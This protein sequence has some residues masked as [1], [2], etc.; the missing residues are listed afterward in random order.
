MTLTTCPSWRRNGRR[1]PDLDSTGEGV[2]GVSADEYGC[3]RCSRS[4]AI[5]SVSCF[6]SVIVCRDSDATTSSRGCRARRCSS[7]QDALT[8]QVHTELVQEL[9]VMARARVGRGEKLLTQEDAVRPGVQA[10]GLELVTH[11]LP[12][13][14]QAHHRMWHQQARGRDRTDEL[15]PVD[16]LDVVPRWTRH[17]YQEVDRHALR[18]RVHRR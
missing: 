4:N 9:V 13:G 14:R 11:R 10:Q 1:T 12:A 2:D 6:W 3:Q 8:G 5:R 15:E 17:L 16:R 7:V 18:M